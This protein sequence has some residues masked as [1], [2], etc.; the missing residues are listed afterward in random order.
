[1]LIQHLEAWKIPQHINQYQ[2]DCILVKQNSWAALKTKEPYQILTWSS[3]P[4]SSRY[5]NMTQ[6][7]KENVRKKTKWNLEK[8]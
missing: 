2:I 6:A 8:L 5:P 3:Q 7:D 4:A 1:M